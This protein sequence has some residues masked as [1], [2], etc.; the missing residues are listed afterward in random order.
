MPGAARQLLATALT[1]P[2]AALASRRYARLYNAAIKDSAFGYAIFFAGFFAN[3]VFSIWSAVGEPWQLQLPC[4]PAACMLQ[5]A[6]SA[7]PSP[8]GRERDGV[9]SVLPSL[10]GRAVSPMWR[11]YGLVATHFPPLPLSSLPAGPP[12]LGEKSHTGFISAINRLSDNTGVSWHCCLLAAGTEGEL[13]SHRTG[14]EG[15]LRRCMHCCLPALGLPR[16]SWPVHYMRPLPACWSICCL[17]CYT[18]I[19]SL[20]VGIVYFI[21]AGFWT[22]ESLWSL[23]VYK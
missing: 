20:Q 12:F 6:V 9:G 5:C 22:L 16:L 4:R 15:R 1:N 23:W 2:A 19:R 21:G 10:A 8:D 11:K 17:Q 18:R 3:L 13:T 7:A 14:A